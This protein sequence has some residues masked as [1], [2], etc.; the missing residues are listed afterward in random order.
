ME[1]SRGKKTENYTGFFLT[2][3]PERI[4][5]EG[6]RNNAERRDKKGREEIQRGDTQSKRET[7]EEK[8]A[9][10][11]SGPFFTFYQ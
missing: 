8:K 7:K 5:A 2:L 10:N 9:Q 3:C 6:T 4:E 1:E 11:C